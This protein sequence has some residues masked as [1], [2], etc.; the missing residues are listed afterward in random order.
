MVDVEGS[1][2]ASGRVHAAFSPYPAAAATARDT[3]YHRVVLRADVVAVVQAVERCCFLLEKMGVVVV[4]VIVDV[5]VA[6]FAAHADEDVAEMCSR[7]GATNF[8]G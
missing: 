1:P 5:V 2:G 3:P 7:E 8:V 4:H 6:V